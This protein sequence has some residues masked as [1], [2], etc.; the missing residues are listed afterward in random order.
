MKTKRFFALGL[1]SFFLLSC[2]TNSIA[3]VYGFQLGKESGTHFGL[4][5]ELKDSLFETTD[6]ALVDKNYKNFDLGLSASFFNSTTTTDSGE[7]EEEDTYSKIIEFFTKNGQFILSGYYGLTSEVTKDK[8]TIIKFGFDIQAIF[9]KIGD[10][11]KEISGEDLPVN[12][13]DI[14]Q[15]VIQDPV[16]KDAI[17]KIVYATHSKTQINLYIPVDLADVYYQLYWY[18]IDVLIATDPGDSDPVIQISLNQTYLDTHLLGSHPTPAD[19][20]EINKT[21]VQDHQGYQFGNTPYR[22]YHALQLSL[23]K[24]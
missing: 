15:E 8:E 2:N 19:I 3:G 6:P 7:E 14:P 17:E 11:Y 18:G 23:L 20:E 12:Y 4:Y 13:D 10:A 21:F 1:L 5:L 22:N 16:T 24:K 9:K